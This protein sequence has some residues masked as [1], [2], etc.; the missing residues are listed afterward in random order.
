MGLF[1]QH[2]VV[3]EWKMTDTDSKI[4]KRTY[5]SKTK[6][7]PKPKKKYKVLIVKP[8]CIVV[9]VDGNGLSVPRNKKDKDVSVGDMIEI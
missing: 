5:T 1:I 2:S 8:S 4:G 6:A 3:E 7:S 9:L